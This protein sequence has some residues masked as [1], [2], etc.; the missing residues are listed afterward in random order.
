[1]TMVA[2]A[3]EVWVRNRPFAGVVE[4]SGSSLKVELSSFLEAL[5]LEAKVENGAVVF[6]D[7]RVPIENGPDGIQMVLLKDIAVGASLKVTRNRE[8]GTIDVYSATAGTQSASDWSDT[9]AGGG[10]GTARSSSAYTIN[11]PSQLELID[12]PATMAAVAAELGGIPNGDLRGIVLSRDE[13]DEAALMLLTVGGMP[14]IGTVTREINLAAAQGFAEGM[15]EEGAR[16][17]TGPT[18]LRIGGRDF[19][20]FKHAQVE[21]SGGV[22]ILE[23]YLNIDAARS[24]LWVVM[25]VADQVNFDRVAAPFQQAVQSLVLK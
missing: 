8:L 13:S 21:G 19:I 4:G 24:Q 14:P 3:Q 10:G 22:T 20:K 7:F 23:S 25:L 1:M 6:G 17:M 5:A 15:E 12:D 16:R 18:E 2:Q 11:V 9:D